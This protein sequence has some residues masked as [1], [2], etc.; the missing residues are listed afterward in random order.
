MSAPLV[1]LSGLY[2]VIRIPGHTW[3]Y[4]PL[5]Q[6]FLDE[7]EN[8]LFHMREK[9]WWTPEH[10]R[11]LVGVLGEAWFQKASGRCGQ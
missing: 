5:V 7:P 4:E 6:H 9:R 10:E 3:K 8:W 11:A 1:C 2:L